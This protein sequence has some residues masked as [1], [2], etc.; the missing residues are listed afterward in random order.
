MKK[1][2]ASASAIAM[3]SI[4]HWPANALAAHP[5][6]TED[7]GTQGTGNFQL[8]LTQD[9]AHDKD[10]GTETRDRSFSAILS[11][12][13]T[14]TL[15][16]I[17]ALPYEHSIERSG[18]TK[19]TVH[20][21]S[22]ME[23]AAKW[24]FYEEGALSLALR[25][26]LGLPTGNDDNGLSSEHYVPSLFGVMTYAIESWAFHLHLGYTRNFHDGAGQRDHVFHASAAAEYSIN[27]SAR[28]VADISTESNPDDAGHPS[29]N[30]IVLGLIYSV[31][32]DV[33]IDLGYR[34]GLS[35]AAADHAWLTGLFIRF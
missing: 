2:S 14:D 11:Y 3:I 6:I 12:G 25:P 15:D 27:E 8:E 35:D 21:F 13:L 10:A 19:T 23:I 30:S 5:L 34:R 26:G 24:R 22:D 17:A 28:L 9:L 1:I 31:T 18:G 32:P 33:D 20:G 4:L 7:T 16:I 29:I